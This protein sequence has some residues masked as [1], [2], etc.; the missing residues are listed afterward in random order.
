MVR[1]ELGSDLVEVNLVYLGLTQVEVMSI[2]AVEA[3]RVTALVVTEGGLGDTL[4]VE[5]F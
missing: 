1:F 5:D 2:P 3:N 4:A